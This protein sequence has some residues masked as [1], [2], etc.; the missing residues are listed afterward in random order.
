MSVL[1]GQNGH[2]LTR[3]RRLSLTRADVTEGLA[4]TMHG[5]VPWLETL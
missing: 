1:A 5:R 2:P 4:I 3:P